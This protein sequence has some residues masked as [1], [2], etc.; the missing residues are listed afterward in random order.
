M[1]NTATPLPLDGIKVVDLTTVLMGPFATQIL[2][3]YGADVIKV[4]A[5]EG[6]PVRGIGPFRHPGMGAIFLNA[7]RNKRSIVLNLREPEG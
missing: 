7:N 2:G 5:P 6:D 1:E 4:E 3:D